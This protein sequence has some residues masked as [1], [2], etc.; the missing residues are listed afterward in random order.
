M[1][2]VQ[3]KYSVISAEI[4]WDKNETEDAQAPV[5]VENKFFSFL[6]LGAVLL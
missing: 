4:N 2:V 6:A 1:A 5:K 3:I